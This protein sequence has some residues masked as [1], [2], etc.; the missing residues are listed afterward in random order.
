L[1]PLGRYKRGSEAAAVPGPTTPT[2]PSLKRGAF[3]YYLRHPVLWQ[4][5]LHPPAPFEGG[6]SV[7]AVNQV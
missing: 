7:I 2:P 3:L 5:Y 1:L 6:L 4:A